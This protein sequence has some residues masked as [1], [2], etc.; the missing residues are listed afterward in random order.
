MKYRNLGKTGLEVSEVGLGTWA[1][2]SSVYGH[3]E[4]DISSRLIHG[5]L[6]DGI[7]FFDTAPLYGSKE[8]LIIPSRRSWVSR[9]LSQGVA[10]LM[11]R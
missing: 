2:G 3:V 1:I 10:V 4:T 7:N 8:D 9:S 5:A 6:E 11:G